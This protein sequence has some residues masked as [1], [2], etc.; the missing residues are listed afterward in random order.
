VV[1]STREAAAARQQLGPDAW[2]VVP[3]IRRPGD[4]AADQARAATPDEACRAGAT[5][6]VVGRPI[7]QASDPAGVFDEL[8]EAAA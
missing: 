1:C 4:A 6:L 5:H 8:V 3:G 7:L 2:I